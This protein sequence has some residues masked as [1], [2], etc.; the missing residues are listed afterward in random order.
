M[1]VDDEAYVR[2][3][4]AA[5]LERQG[6]AVR[7]AASVAEASRPGELAGVDLVVADLKMPGEDG[8]A[9]V[10]RLAVEEPSLPVV[11]L[12]GH[13][14]V[15]SAVEC[16]KTGAVD[17]LLKPTD[18]DE[19]VM[20]IER[21]LRQSNMSRE[22]RYLRSGEGEGSGR[23]EPIGVSEGWRRV[24]E[25]AET[26]A[27]VDTSVLILGES[28][29]GKEEV[30]KVLHYKSPRADGPFVRVNCAAIPS[31]LFESEFFGHRRGAFT[32]A[33]SNREGRFRVAHGG[34]LFLDEINSLA[35]TAQAKVLR[36]L[37]DGTFERVGDTRPTVVDVRLISA[38]NADLA[39]EVEA[40][41]FRADLF[42][43][44]N[45]MTLEI[46]PLRERRDDVPVL[47]EVFLE[48]I[49]AKLAKPVRSIHPET[50]AALRSYR[51]P[52]NVRELKNV[53]ER[54][55][56]IEKSHELLPSS[57]P[58]DTDGAAPVAGSG[59][60]NLKEG[61]AAA[62]RRFL[63]EALERSEGVRREAA[64]LLGIDERNMAYYLRKHG[65]MEKGR[66]R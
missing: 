52:G 63:C 11:V 18:P 59:D 43:R 14:T 10:R 24:M 46:P 53:I 47:A 32:G 8:H 65:L 25:L 33:V 21:A 49:A 4:L 29:T 22:L 48:E 28:G 39:S 55:V 57:L 54:G 51:W 62:E 26:A 3:S 58:F 60:L 12:T 31:E 45:V 66:G 42:Y 41:R 27:P 34:T 64:K 61:L 19:L 17:Y 6:F 30:A 40:G 38:S 13:G 35:S 50:L 37:Q 56:L 15:S 5:A 20:V 1:V 36:V 44:I 7:T 23:R 16:M 2:D 9:L